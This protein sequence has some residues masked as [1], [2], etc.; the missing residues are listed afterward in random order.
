[1]LRFSRIICEAHPHSFFSSKPP[2][3]TPEDENVSFSP[4]MLP[5]ITPNAL[6][7][8]EF[9]MTPI[10]IQIKLNLNLFVFNKRMSGA[11]KVAGGCGSHS[12]LVEMQA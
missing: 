2:K 11:M 9:S 3:S 7:I 1:M 8:S 5:K 10:K 12:S 6:G 4:E